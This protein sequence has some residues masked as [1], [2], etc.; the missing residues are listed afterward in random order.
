M[1]GYRNRPEESARALRDGW[2]YTGD[3]GELD[4]EGYLYIR[5]RKKEM[6]IVSGY[7]VYPR[8]IEEILHRNPEVK[9]AAVVGRTD[10]YRGELPVAFIVPVSGNGAGRGNAAGL[11]QRKPG[12]LQGP[13]GVPFLQGAAEDRGR[14]GG[15]GRPCQ[16]SK[17]GY[18]GFRTMN[19]SVVIPRPIVIPAPHRHSR[20]PIVIPAQ[21]GIQ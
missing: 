3:I 10:A 12:A 7:N 15:Q 17:P 1:R 14:Q 11:L 2:L 20:A 13:G 5:G 8:E 4:E 19:G 18:R 16:E 21:A 9:E 6:L